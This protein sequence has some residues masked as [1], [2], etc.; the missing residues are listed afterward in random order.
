M[1]IVKQKVFN[2]MLLENE[3]KGMIVIN[4][5]KHFVNSVAKEYER[6]KDR[7]GM[8]LIVVE[9][10]EPKEDI[11]KRVQ[12]NEKQW[13]EE[14]GKRVRYY[15][16][17][18]TYDDKFIQQKWTVGITPISN[19]F[20]NGMK[21][22]LQ[23]KYKHWDKLTSEEQLNHISKIFGKIFDGIPCMIITIL[24]LGEHSYYFYTLH[25]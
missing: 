16:K 8:P 19:L 5:L 22:T 3:T 12:E 21:P 17:E 9:E 15:S 11:E 25:K 6:T 14:E 4:C 13:I 23:N 24:S 10:K 2:E 1:A 18:L 20:K 7:I